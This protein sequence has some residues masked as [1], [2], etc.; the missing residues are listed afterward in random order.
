MRIAML[1]D[2]YGGVYVGGGI[3][4]IKNLTKYLKKNYS[5]EILIFSQPFPSF[6]ARLLYNFW[7]IPVVI[8]NHIKNPFD[9]IH[10]HAYSPAIPAKILSLILKKPVV[11]TIHGCNNLDL[12]K[13]NLRKKTLI[14]FLENYFLTQIKY[15]AQITVAANFLQYPNV[16]NKIYV[17]SNGVNDKKD[18][19]KQFN[20]DKKIILFVGRLE[21]IKGLEILFK[22]LHNFPFA[23]ELRII[24]EGQEKENLVAL[25]KTLKIDKMI[26]FL[27]KKIGIDLEK[28][29]KNSDLFILPSLSEGFPLTILEAMSFKLPVLATKVGANPD[30]IENNKTGF[31]VE[32]NK[33]NDLRKKIVWIFTNFKK[34][35]FVGEK[36]FLY[37]KNYSWEKMA[38]KTYQIYLEVLQNEK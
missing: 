24:G 32:P 17:I 27:G 3:V 21:K 22:A 15:D 18:F 7:I 5:C 9:L 4:H 28:E 36:A 20:H 14:Y 1:I 2:V 30:M 19:V 26:N 12:V 33:I 25:S 11:Y 38:E 35:T 16:N 34:A 29:Y 13:M 10:A 6:F 37:V 8:Y 23:F 31:L